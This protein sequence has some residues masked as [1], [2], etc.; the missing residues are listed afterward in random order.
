MPENSSYNDNNINQDWIFE[1]PNLLNVFHEFLDDFIDDDHDEHMKMMHEYIQSDD[2]LP[3]KNTFASTIKILIHN[4]TMTIEYIENKN[5]ILFHELPTKKQNEVENIMVRFASLFDRISLII[6]QFTSGMSEST[7]KIIHN[8]CK[9]IRDLLEIMLKFYIVLH[10]TIKHNVAKLKK[11]TE[12]RDSKL[13]LD[14]TIHQIAFSILPTSDAF[15]DAPFSV[16]KS[17]IILLRKYYKEKDYKTSFVY[18]GQIID[19]LLKINYKN[20][21]KKSTS[22]I[23]KRDKL[24]SLFP[25]QNLLFDPDVI[26]GLKKT[27]EHRNVAAH[28]DDFDY[29][30]KN[31]VTV[32]MYLLFMI[33]V[34]VKQNINMKS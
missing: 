5:K 32:Y 8:F 26:D 16:L 25:K 33:Y 15:D 1:N 11:P 34:I 22:K 4:F 7:Q 9:I 20:R 21:N 2:M 30:D 6:K 12:Y 23:L 3:I 27:W 28:G 13:Q 10:Y 29:I 24:S 31:L 14:E 18:I 17:R 19:G